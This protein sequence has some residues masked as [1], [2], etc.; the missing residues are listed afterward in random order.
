MAKKKTKSKTKSKKTVAS[1]K[2][3][4]KAKKGNKPSA[5]PVKKKST[6]KKAAAKKATKK[7]VKAPKKKAKETKEEPVAEVEETENLLAE[8]EAETEA[9]ADVIVGDFGGKGDAAIAGFDLEELA[10]LA[11]TIESLL[12]AA[13]RPL[14]VRDLRELTGEIDP[15][16][17]KAAVEVT[18]RYFEDRGLQLST[19]AG[20][21]RFR[22]NPKNSEVV[23]KLVE[24]KPVRL[25]R[26]Q[27]ETLSIVAYRQ[28][29]TRP[30]IDEIRGVDSGSTLRV[31]LDRT[32]IRILG[33]KEEAGRPLLYG[34]TKEFLEFFNLDHLK[35]LPTLREYHEL[36]DDSMAEVEK[37]APIVATD[38]GNVE[39][40]EEG[41]IADIPPADTEED[42]ANIEA[43]SQEGQPDDDLAVGAA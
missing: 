8:A 33:K 20:A 7:P 18:R 10:P 14:T 24:G 19:V 4:S 15:K 11:S 3:S 26:A 30:E 39:A 25:S 17:V 2:A 35:E 38:E 40:E 41:E 13:T 22:T 6:A 31:L 27:L 16:R 21:F 28:P 29:I 5:K 36:T 32:L 42:T 12:F 37:L 34:T 1:R 43:E 9:E 23:Q